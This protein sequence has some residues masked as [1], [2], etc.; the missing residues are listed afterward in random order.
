MNQK[1]VR[2][3]LIAG[4]VL[5][6]GLIIYRVIDGLSGDDT[7]LP[8]A[9]PPAKA[10]LLADKSDSFNLIADYPDPFLPVEDSAGARTGVT[11]AVTTQ[12]VAPPPAPLN[13]TRPPDPD[14]YKEGMI[15][16][17]GMISNPEKKIKVATVNIKGTEYL[18]KEGDKVMGIIIKKIEGERIII[19]HRKKNIP[20][21][22]S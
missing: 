3:C 20:V 6:W 12:V 13:N 7:I 2:Y 4:V 16:Y 15:Q 8:A 14:A 11:S 17:L 5:V 10:A 22:R 1:I 19:V 21:N 9:L 18:V